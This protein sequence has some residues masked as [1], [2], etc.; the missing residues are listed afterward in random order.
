VALGDGIR[1]RSVAER[2]FELYTDRGWEEAEARI[3]AA[4]ARLAAEAW[5]QFGVALANDERT[6]D[7][8]RA[9]TRSREL[10]PERTDTLLFLADLERDD[11]NLEA[12]IEH[13]RAL[14][15]AA[16]GAV[17]Q[18][19][20]LARLLGEREAHE[21]IVQVLL[22]FRSNISIELRVR[23]A[24]ALLAQ[25][26]YEDVISVA[27]A[28]L[29]DAERELRGFM[30]R[31]ARNDL[32]E[33]RARA[34]HLH[35]EAFA[36]LHGREQVIEA[37]AH[38]GR[39]DPH[40]GA[41][42][43][44]LGEARM[45]DA[46]PWTPDTALRDLDGTVAFGEA[47]I[48][49]G[50]KSRG[51]CHL[52]VAALRR[53]KASEARARFEAAR[54][55]DDRNFAAYL[56]IGAA[57][58]H[59]RFRAVARVGRL[60]APPESLPAG[61]AQVLV[62]WPLLT[63]AE[64]VCVHAAVAPLAAQL[65]IVAAADGIARVL[66]IDARL[67]DLPEFAEDAGVRLDDAR[68]LDAIT[69]ASSPRLCA[70]KVEELLNFSGELGWVFAHEL[71]HLVHFHLS[72]ERCAELDELFEELSA[73]EFVLTTYQTRNT[74]EFFAVAYEDYLADLYT[75]PSAREGGFEYLEGVFAFIDQLTG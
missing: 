39:L 3:A 10:A 72:D 41:N 26:R 16:P 9:L 30:P 28:A 60:P 75:L 61:M 69:G 1:A 37:R 46:P 59:D 15:A 52:G 42:F 51:L 14:L 23:L 31:E 11:G 55:A 73:N 29:G 68:C 43:R 58:D 47:L 21:E 35:D 62:D 56:G 5:A 65:P 12:A 36:R 20:D 70:S 33:Y 18:A 63:Q 4:P 19:L 13:Y 74:A 57:I 54:D 27:G 67:V 7:A 71:A 2:A 44:L 40:S 49:K 25:D 45:V 38:Q 66:P 17:T 22:P 48:A 8:R 64:Q 32:Q 6:Y 53:H 34:S 50:E 24:H